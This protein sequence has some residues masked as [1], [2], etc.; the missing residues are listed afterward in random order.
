MSSGLDS[1]TEQLTDISIRE[2]VVDGL[3]PE[4]DY[5]IAVR[6]YYQLLGPAGTTTVKLQGIRSI[7]IALNQSSLKLSLLAG[8]NYCNQSFVFVFYLHQNEQ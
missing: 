8:I 2:Y 5:T 6:G 4:R 7:I 3:L 1:V